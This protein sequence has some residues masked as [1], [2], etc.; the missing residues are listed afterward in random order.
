VEQ[1]SLGF[2]EVAR[3]IQENIPSDRIIFAALKIDYL[4]RFIS[5]SPHNKISNNPDVS[6]DT[7]QGTPDLFDLA[8][9][10][11]GTCLW[12]EDYGYDGSAQR[13]SFVGDL[14]RCAAREGGLQFGA[15]I[16]GN[17]IGTAAEAIP[18]GAS[19]RVMALAGRGAA[20]IEIYAFEQGLA[21]T[22]DS[23]SEISARTALSRARW[24]FSGLQRLYLVNRRK[25]AKE[26][27]PSYSPKQARLGILTMQSQT[28]VSTTA[29]FTITRSN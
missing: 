22:A 19:Y 25:H 20:G 8:R 6:Q 14:L 16:Y 23:W 4:Q 21:G 18:D 3:V 26:P 10:K 13:A 24:P 11:G 12:T 5:P 15:Y 29:T 17:H 7:A 28:L 27:S 9:K 2:A 1:V